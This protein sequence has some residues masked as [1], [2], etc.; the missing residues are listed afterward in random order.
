MAAKPP[1]IVTADTGLQAVLDQAATAGGQVA[2]AASQIIYGPWR[3]F[4]T[5][6]GQ[7]APANVNR[8][9]RAT[10]AIKGSGR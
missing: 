2:S 7:S 10:R 4:A 8:A 6:I 1:K 9:T 5:A 3:A